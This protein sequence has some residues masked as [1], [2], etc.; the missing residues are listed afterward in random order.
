MQRLL[1]E[2][3]PYLK[4][5]TVILSVIAS[6]FLLQL[7]WSFLTPFSDIILIVFLAWLFSFLLGPLIKRLTD[8]GLSQFV[9]AI[10]AYLLIAVFLII[11]SLL[12]FPT[13]ITQLTELSKQ[14]PQ[15]SSEIP[16]WVKQ[17]EV[18]LASRGVE[19][20]L[21]QTIRERLADFSALGSNFANQ[22]VNV[23]ASIFNTL[24]AFALVLIIS[25]YF[26]IDGAKIKNGF[27][28]LLPES[29][30]D[31]AEFVNRTVNRSFAGF[32]RGQAILAVISGLTTWIILI[33]F[34]VDYA[35]TAALTSG[36]LTLVPIIG[37]PL[38]LVPPV[39][40]ALL[41]APE[42]AWVV[43]II[44]LLLQQIEFNVLGPIILKQTIGLH[45][46]WVILAFLVGFKIGGG[47]GAIFA[48]PIAG[49]L[50]II[51]KEIIRSKVKSQPKEKNHH[52]KNLGY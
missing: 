13:V 21:T 32:I 23:I 10:L 5:L 36:L 20:D 50:E 43:F 48:A 41:S 19:V 25:F 12:I 3:S 28:A 40:V 39:I 9:G 22:L 35:A 4:F 31:N 46:I 29:W 34:G 15:L 49:I 52:N 30:Q 6:L 37:G 7:I 38:A 18:Y 2:T 26:S 11:V 27:L 42:L 47:W 16:H 17:L 24:F 33:L 8:L 51:G 14:L 1:E 45:P 44:L